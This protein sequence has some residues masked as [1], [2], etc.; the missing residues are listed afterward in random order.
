MRHR[1]AGNILPWSSYY[2]PSQQRLKRG[3]LRFFPT[4][5]L[6][7]RENHLEISPP[8]CGTTIPPRRLRIWGARVTPTAMAGWSG[9]ALGIGLMDDI[10]SCA[11]LIERTVAECKTAL[12]RVAA[13]TSEE[14]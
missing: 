3:G 11:E 4:A 12:S 1:G 7:Y 5:T 2:R 13:L 8:I 9:P 14:G 10:P 6:R